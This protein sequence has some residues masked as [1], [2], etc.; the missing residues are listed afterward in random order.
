M[1]GLGR[2]RNRESLKEACWLYQLSWQALCSTT[3]LTLLLHK[4]LKA[5]KEDTQYHPLVSP[6]MCTLQTQTGKHTQPSHIHIHTHLIK[7]MPSE[8]KMSN[9]PYAPSVGRGHLVISLRDF[10]VAS[11]FQ[12]QFLTPP[13]AA[14]FPRETGFCSPG[15]TLV[16]NPGLS[17]RR[18]KPLEGDWEKDFPLKLKPQWDTATGLTDRREITNRVQA[19]TVKGS[20]SHQSHLYS[21]CIF[22]HI[23]FP[24]MDDCL[25][26]SCENSRFLPMC[27]ILSPPNNAVYW[28]LRNDINTWHI[29]AEEAKRIKIKYPLI[30][31]WRE[32]LSLGSSDNSVVNGVMACQRGLMPFYRQGD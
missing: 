16:D 19:R 1:A 9:V 22:P 14:P 3:G 10:S 13:L 32:E 26:H 8:K 23:S 12:K 31:S 27:V 18:K 21:P 5:I 30:P 2:Q 7:K 28:S 20:S 4:W 6:Y 24:S 15:K 25:K 29:Q 11:I 17:H